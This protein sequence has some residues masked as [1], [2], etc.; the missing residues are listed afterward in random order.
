[1]QKDRD[2]IAKALKTLAW[3]VEDKWE[4]VGVREL[5]AAMEVSPSSAHRILSA[6][7]AAGFVRQDPRTSRYSLGLEFVRLCHLAADR[8]PLR[9]IA[10]RHMS[11]FAARHAETVLLGV[12]DRE[13]QKLMFT[14]SIDSP[15]EL[16]YVIELNKWVD[17]NAG[18]TSLAILVCLDDSEVEAI[19]QKNGLAAF[20]DKV[21]L[22]FPG[23]RKRLMSI[24]SAGYAYAVGPRFEGA[25]GLAAPILGS[26]DRVVGGICV[27]IPP[28]RYDN[29]RERDLAK[30]LITCADR[31]SLELGS[32]LAAAGRL[33]SGSEMRRQ[34]TNV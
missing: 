27:G 25:I 2:P 16:R 15:H 31:I 1:M 33:A 7:G 22:G 14:A 18:C 30:D 6:L 8:M 9:R 34:L 17:L 28:Q 32:S 3:M 26:D 29:R 20:T 23:L 12:Y 13:H 5:A 24:R 10:L 11:D 19:V 21:A 4:D